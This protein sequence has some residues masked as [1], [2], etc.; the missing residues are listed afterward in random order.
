[1]IDYSNIKLA[2]ING[3]YLFLSDYVSI[4]STFVSP[5]PLSNLGLKGTGGYQCG[6][7]GERRR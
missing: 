6:R 1:M 2:Q 3:E 5:T 7:R 4:K